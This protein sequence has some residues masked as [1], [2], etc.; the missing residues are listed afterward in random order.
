MVPSEGSKKFFPSASFFFPCMLKHYVGRY[1][2]QGEFYHSLRNVFK[3][4]VL[5]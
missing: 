4:F 5:E 1:V 3:I 2:E